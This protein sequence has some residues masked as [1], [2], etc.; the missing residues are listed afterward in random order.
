MWEVLTIDKVSKEIRSKTMQAVKSKH[1]K[2]E[3][4][5]TKALWANGYRFR[6]NESSLMGK[7]DISIKKYK[8]V[9]FIDSCFWHGCP[10]HGRIPK[11][12][13]EFWTEKIQRNIQRDRQVTEYYRLSGWF[14]LRLW[15]HEIS[16]NL[17]LVIE[18]IVMHI[19]QAKCL[20]LSDS[21][22]KHKT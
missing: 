4:K 21:G 11:S 6:R 9:I 3:N 7:P 18:K 22:V 13:I 2:L 12:N 1:T 16:D 14:I 10:I 8:I 5:V 20:L 15:E 19:K 17:D